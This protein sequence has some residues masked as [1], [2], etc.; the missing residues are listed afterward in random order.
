MRYSVHFRLGEEEFPGATAVYF[1][2]VSEENRRL[3][4]LKS[5]VEVNVLATSTTV[6]CCH[7]RCTLAGLSRYSDYCRFGRKMIDLLVESY[8]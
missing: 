5:F 4:I 2:L 1:L 6:V 3:N 8:C 7:P